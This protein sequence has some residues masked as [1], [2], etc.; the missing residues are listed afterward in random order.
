MQV[1]LI[2][3]TASENPAIIKRDN[4]TTVLGQ[5]HS[6]LGQDG[7]LVF[8]LQI[9]LRILRASLISKIIYYK[10]SINEL[11][12]IGLVTLIYNEKAARGPL[13]CFVALISI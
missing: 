12:L 2:I 5:N 8:D 9:F 11:H 10:K 4:N 7:C 3:L 13:L 1:S 6:N